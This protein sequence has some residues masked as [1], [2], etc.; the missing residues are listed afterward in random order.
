MA[1]IFLLFAMLLFVV[2]SLRVHFE[3]PALDE[4]ACST[5]HIKFYRNHTYVCSYFTW[6]EYFRVHLEQGHDSRN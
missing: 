2:F 5:R 1:V 3:V 6:N 4:H